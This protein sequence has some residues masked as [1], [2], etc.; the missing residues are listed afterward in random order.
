MQGNVDGPAS[1]P[2]SSDAAEE[3]DDTVESDDPD[4]DQW[5][6]RPIRSTRVVLPTRY[7]HE[8]VMDQ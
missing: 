2:E 8:Y 7:R 4:S 6:K 5:P 1:M 3:S